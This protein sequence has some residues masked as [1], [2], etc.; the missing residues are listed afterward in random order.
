MPA[1]TVPEVTDHVIGVVPVAVKPVLGYKT[2]TCPVTRKDGEVMVG[3]LLDAPIV[4]DSAAE[5][6]NP[7]LFVARNTKPLVVAST[8]GVP[9]MTPA[10]D[11]LRPA[12]NV[13]ACSDIVG[14]GEPVKASVKV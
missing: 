11:T 8:V 3:A 2:P 4:S 5:S 1:G 6:A 7:A 13:P 12:G 14:V 10:L 9:L